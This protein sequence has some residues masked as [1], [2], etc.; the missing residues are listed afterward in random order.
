VRIL[1]A[2]M[3]IPVK[4]SGAQFEK[5]GVHH[6]DRYARHGRGS[7]QNRG[8]APAFFWLVASVINDDIA[9]IAQL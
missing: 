1:A 4:G 8:D 9:P 7:R 2:K 3:E 5:T 6:G